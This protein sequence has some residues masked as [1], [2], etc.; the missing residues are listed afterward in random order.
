MVNLSGKTALVA[1]ASRHVG[2]ASALALAEAGA[3]L[4]VHYSAT[5]GAVDTMVKPFAAGQVL[6]LPRKL[7]GVIDHLVGAHRRHPSCTRIEPTPPAA[8]R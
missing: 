6:D 4:L 1:G 7:L 2:R 8:L 3:Q 5:K